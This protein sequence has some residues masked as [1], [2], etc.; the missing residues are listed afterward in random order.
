M[1]AAEFLKNVQTQG[2]LASKDQAMQATQATLSVLGQRLFGGERKDMFAQL[3]PEFQS[4]MQEAGAS[5]TFGLDDFF[6]RISQKEGVDLSEAEEHAR[7]VISVLCQSITKGEIEDI[8]SQ[9][10]KS[11]WPMFESRTMH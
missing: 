7:A 8:R 9:L 3:P 6:Q 10:P 5:E 4:F 11:F 2:N 1:K